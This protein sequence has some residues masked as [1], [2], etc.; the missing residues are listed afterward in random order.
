MADIVLFVTSAL[1]FHHFGQRINL[2]RADINAALH[3]GT[4]HFTCGDFFTQPLTE[5]LVAAFFPHDLGTELLDRDFLLPG[6]V[7][8]GLIK[9]RIG[10]L[11]THPFCHL[12]LQAVHD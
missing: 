12:Q 2:L 10:D 1:L 8:D 5:Q 7:F 3:V 4:Q 11:Q 6:D 9:L